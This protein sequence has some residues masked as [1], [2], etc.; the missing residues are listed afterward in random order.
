MK[1]IPTPA[2]GRRP[3]CARLAAPFLAALAACLLSSCEEPPPAEPPVDY[4][5]EIRRLEARIESRFEEMGTALL[6]VAAQADRSAFWQSVAAVLLFVGGIAFV[7]G[8]AIGSKARRE[9]LDPAAICAAPSGPRDPLVSFESFESFARHANPD[10]VRA[11][12]PALRRHEP[13]A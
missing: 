2:P 8:A 4:G 6:A 3:R 5:A 1:P 13:A 10:P 7:G 12:G 11:E 9:R